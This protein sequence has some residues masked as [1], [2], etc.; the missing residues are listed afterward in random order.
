MIGSSQELRET[1]D[2]FH[3]LEAKAKGVILGSTSPAF[4]LYLT[5]LDTSKEMWDIL[6]ERLDKAAS[7]NG[8]LA[9]RQQF[10]SL[11][12]VPGRPLGEFI[13]H[14]HDIRFQLSSSD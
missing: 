14:L 10:L 3:Q 7:I 6:R 5:G 11:I 13:S 4:R 12:P 9:L 2:S 8:R 1:R